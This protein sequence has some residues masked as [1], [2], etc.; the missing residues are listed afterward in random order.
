MTDLSWQCAPRRRRG[1]SLLPT[2]V[3]EEVGDVGFSSAPPEHSSPRGSLLPPLPFP[4]VVSLLHRDRGPGQRH[5]TQS[6]DGASLCSR[7]CSVCRLKDGQWP[8]SCVA[9]TCGHSRFRPP[10]SGLSPRLA[11]PA[12]PPPPLRRSVA[13]TLPSLAQPAARFSPQRSSSLPRS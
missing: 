7:C 9:A 4:Q 10:A 6:V 5:S 3:D 13:P 12:F 11:S 1:R 8:A 2:A